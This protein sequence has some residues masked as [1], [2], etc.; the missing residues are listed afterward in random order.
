MKEL[1]TDAILYETKPTVILILTTAD[2]TKTE[3][4][5]NT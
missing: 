2:E 3:F 4:E 5:A 1:A